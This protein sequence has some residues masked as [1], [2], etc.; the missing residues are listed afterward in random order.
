M[1]SCLSELVSG[2]PALSVCSVG[3]FTRL[4]CRV[5]CIQ[6]RESCRVDNR[7][8][9]RRNH[10][11]DGVGRCCPIEPAHEEVVLTVT[12]GLHGREARQDVGVLPSGQDY[13]W[14]SGSVH[15]SISSRPVGRSVELIAGTPHDNKPHGVLLGR[16]EYQVL[17]GD[18]GPRALA[19]AAARA[20]WEL[21]DPVRGAG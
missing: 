15:Q 11:R 18:G 8:H 5:A 21:L 13:L 4:G 9:L 14:A 16:T 12:C 7:R 17:A 19:E 20:G 6:R 2:Q 1:N 10:R 3:A